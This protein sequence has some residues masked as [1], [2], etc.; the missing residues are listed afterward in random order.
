M[1]YVYLSFLFVY[2]IGIRINFSSWDNGSL[3]LSHFL[4]LFFYFFP[5]NHPSLM[6]WVQLPQSHYINIIFP[7]IW[8][9]FCYFFPEFCPLFKLKPTKQ[10]KNHLFLHSP[11]LDA[12]QSKEKWRFWSG[13][14]VDFLFKQAE[15]IRAREGSGSGQAQR[16]SE[17]VYLQATQLYC[18]F[19]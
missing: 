3:D 2:F 4:D 14:I 12:L 5:R 13:E 18:K 6:T 15:D 10:T 16:V 9:N 17:V 19:P 8:F 7:P 11:G 1:I